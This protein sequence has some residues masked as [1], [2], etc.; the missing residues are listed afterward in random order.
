MEAMGAS[1]GLVAMGV[2]MSDVANFASAERE[3]TV[4]VQATHNE[5][6]G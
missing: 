6:Q 4:I 5:Y 3:K 2:E 1:G